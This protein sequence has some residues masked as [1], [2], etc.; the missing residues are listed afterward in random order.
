MIAHLRSIFFS[1][2]F[3]FGIETFISFYLLGEK[4]EFFIVAALVVISFFAGYN[5]GKKVLYSFLPLAI[6]GSSLGLLYFIDDLIERQIFGFLV[7]ILFYTALLGIKRICKNPLDMTARSLF[8]ATLM[9]TVFL[10]YAVTYG[11]YINFTVP[12]WLFI[13]GHFV[14]ITFITFISLRS[15]LS[16]YRRILLYSVAIGFAMIQLAWMANFWPFGYLTMAA[17]SLMF[18]YILWDLVQMVFL[19]TLSKKRVIITIIYCVVLTMTVLLTT[20]WLLVG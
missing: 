8:S 12:L 14:F 15:Y 6:T 16:D 4:W 19:G 13:L 1:I 17:I 9:A 20:Q 7:A 3:L 11:F 5:V 2:L 18:Y 10:F